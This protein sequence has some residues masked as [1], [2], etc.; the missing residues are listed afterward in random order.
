MLNKNTASSKFNI[1]LLW[2]MGALAVSAVIGV[3]LNVIIIKFYGSEVL[4]V[5]N[6][7]YAVYILLSQLAV[8]GVHLSVQKYVPEYYSEKTNLNHIVTS[9]LVITVI[10]SIITIAIAYLFNKL[11]GKITNS[12]GVLHGFKYVIWGLLF[13]SM[14]KVLLSFLNGIREM[15]AFA[16]FQLLRFV[17]ML[18]F[19]VYFIFTNKEG[20]L[21][22]M[23][24]P[25]TELFLFFI[26]FIY[27]IRFFKIS[28]HNGFRNW[29]TENYRFGNK[30]LLGN[31]LS[32]I[33]TKVD[34]FMLGIFLT[35]SMVGI[36]SI[37][38]TIAEGFL[39]LPVLMRNNIN[40]VI[41]KAHTKKGFDILK[42]V[43][44]KSK[45]D[46]YKIIALLGLLSI[47]GFPLFL[48]VFGIKEDFYLIWSIYAVLN[49]GVIITGG[50]LP[51]QMIFN[52]LGHPLIQT[53]F[54]FLLFIS[55]V[56]MNAIFIP[57]TGVIG[58]AIGTSVSMIIQIVI[59]KYLVKR[60]TQNKLSI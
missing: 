3:L 59:M 40:P 58:A 44:R 17:F 36:Y 10:T 38:A 5:F 11:P 7:I 9:A 45:K 54:I 14:N 56:I 32:D 42:Q 21:L 1:D 48:I 52:Q 27:A 35:D 28:I 6:Q 33:N 25:L 39:Q 51:F 47:A 4:G 46:F 37:A 2:N 53:L 57:L 20:Y 30:A 8:S 31:F 13:F 15:K 41:T 49:L 55:N 22:A 34:V 29:L 23:M 24:L 16:I 26:L 18:S 19:L 43:I 60:I 50:Y 12:E